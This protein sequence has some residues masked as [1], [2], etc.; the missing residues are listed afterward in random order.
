MQ[1]HVPHPFT[2][3]VRVETPVFLVKMPKTEWTMVEFQSVSF[4]IIWSWYRNHNP[5]TNSRSTAADL[6]APES[7]LSSPWSIGS[8]QGPTAVQRPRQMAGFW[9]AFPRV[10]NPYMEVSINWG[11]PK[12]DG[13]SW[14]IHQWIPRK[15]PNMYPGFEKWGTP[16]LGPSWM[17]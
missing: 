4:Q 14:K 15:P 17:S 10:S 16:G 11:Y 6:Q 13:L 3:M 12:M 5:K 2:A 7:P 9:M 8:A 1:S